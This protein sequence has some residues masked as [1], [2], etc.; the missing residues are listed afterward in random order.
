[1]NEG[2]EEKFASDFASLSFLRSPYCMDY[3]LC[4]ECLVASGSELKLPVRAIVRCEIC[5]SEPT[6][7]LILFMWSSHAFAEVK[8]GPDDS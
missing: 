8:D 5:R 4:L 2:F 1:M 3:Q 6:S 7:V